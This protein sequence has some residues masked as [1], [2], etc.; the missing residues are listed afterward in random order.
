V[1]RGAVVASEP[2]DQSYGIRA[3]GV[4]DLNGINIVFGQDIEPD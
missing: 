2:T 3:F 1:E 4:Q